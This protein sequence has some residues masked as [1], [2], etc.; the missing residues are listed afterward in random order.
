MGHAVQ[1][2]LAPDERRIATRNLAPE[3]IAEHHHEAI[4][5]VRFVG[6]IQPAHCRH[7]SEEIKKRAVGSHALDL[8]RLAQAGEVVAGSSDRSEGL[9]QVCG[10]GDVFGLQWRELRAEQVEPGKIFANYH[11]PVQLRRR[12]RPR[13]EEHTSELQSLAYLVC[14]LLLEKK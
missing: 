14:R 8:L 6:P 2:E 11:Y 1:I 12:N 3:G 4:G 7:D 5:T 13:S 10:P 9:E